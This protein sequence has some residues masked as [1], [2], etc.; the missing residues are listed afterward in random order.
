MGRGGAAPR[1]RRKETFE[2]VGWSEASG[3][4]GGRGVIREWR[5][6]RGDK[7]GDCGQGFGAKAM[8]AVSTRVAEAAVVARWGTDLPAACGMLARGA[9]RRI[10]AG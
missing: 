7:G 8:L 10:E 2:A 5:A 1:A 9:R 4:G 3:E 6:G